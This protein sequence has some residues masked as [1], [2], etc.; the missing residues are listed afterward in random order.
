MPAFLFSLHRD[1]YWPACVL[2][3]ETSRSLPTCL[4]IR[5]QRLVYAV[6]PRRPQRRNP[7]QTGGELEDTFTHAE[8]WIPFLHPPQ[9]KNRGNSIASLNCVTAW[10]GGITEFLLSPSPD[11][12]MRQRTKG[13]HFEPG[14]AFRPRATLLADGA[15]GL[16]SK[17]AVA[18]RNG[19]E[20]HTWIGIKEVSHAEEGK[21]VPGVCRVLPL[22]ALFLFLSVLFRH[23]LGWPLSA[24]TYGGG[25]EYHMADGLVS[26]GLV[27]LGYKNPCMEPYREFQL[28]KHHPPFRAL[29]AGGTRIAYDARALTDGGLQSLPRLDFS[30]GALLTGTKAHLDQITTCLTLALP[31]LKEL[32]DAFGPPFVQPMVNTIQS[33]IN[34]VQ[35][36]KQNKSEC[37]QL[38]ENIHHILYAVVELYIKSETVALLPPSMLDNIGKFVE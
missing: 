21:Y 19:K 29:L 25:W 18:M 6:R 2:T 7:P 31:L 35:N 37:A 34:L 5:P 15:H 23:T 22:L 38:M 33:L 1:T 4:R 9:I 28:T 17:Q 26:I 14:M 8:Y 32:N 12:L 13:P 30:G 10:L 20:A 11:A 36:V 16:L 27:S 24:H 3:S